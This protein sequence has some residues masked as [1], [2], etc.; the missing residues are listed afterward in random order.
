MKRKFRGLGKFE[1]FSLLCS[2]CVLLCLSGCEMYNRDAV[3]AI[4]RELKDVDVE[5]IEVLAAAKQKNDF[6]Y[7][8]IPVDS[9]PVITAYIDNPNEFALDMTVGPLSSDLHSVRVSGSVLSLASVSRRESDALQVT[10]SPATPDMEH[11]DFTVSFVPTSE[12]RDLVSIQTR[13]VTLRYNTPPGV[14]LAVM[15]DE[16]GELKFLTDEE[17]SIV[18]S[19]TDKGGRGNV[20]WAWPQG[21]TVAGGAPE[22]AADCAASF[23]LNGR[24]YTPKECATGKTLVAEGGA[25]YDVYSLQVAG[26]SSV[27]LYAKDVESVRGPAIFSG[28]RSCAVVFDAAGGVFAETQEQEHVV[29]QQRGTNVDL[30]RI[31]HPVREGFTFLGWLRDSALLPDGS[32]LGVMSD[33]SLQALWEDESLYDEVRDVQGV[34]D[35][36]DDSISFSWSYPLS[37]DFARTRLTWFDGGGREMDSKLLSRDELD[38]TVQLEDGKVSRFCLQTVSSEKEISDGLV[39]YT[40][41]YVMDGSVEK[42]VAMEGSR[43]AEKE[44]LVPEGQE[45]QGWFLDEEGERPFDGT[46]TIAGSLVLYAKWK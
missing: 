31:P 29:Y 3:A 1:F 9:S 34:Y 12:S 23:V 10:L 26:V 18:Y 43:L 38:C 20:F 37:E 45:F 44:V 2:V 8:C 24:A 25:V 46:G 30:S 7:T 6:G 27:E 32:V 33:T 11:T 15:V 14:P 5:Q 28:D 21:M 40:V 13:S 19:D 17:W 22:Q 35:L 41:T 4:P 16:A 39:F 42:I 36:E